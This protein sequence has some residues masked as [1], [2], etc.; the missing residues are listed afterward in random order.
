MSFT[1]SPKSMRGIA[2]CALVAGI[3]ATPW[4]IAH[5]AIVSS[6]INVTADN[7]VVTLSLSGTYE[8]GLFD[9]GGSEIVAFHGGSAHIL[10]VNAD[11][12]AVQVLDG[13]D[14][15]DPA[16]L[17][18]V[19]VAGTVDSLGD[20]IPVGAVA[21]S[22][23]VRPDGLGVIAVESNVKTDNGWVVFFDASASS[24]QIL[25][26]VRVG[27]Q[28]DNVVISDDGEFAVTANEGEPNDDYTVDPQ[29]SISVIELPEL[30][31]APVQA[32]VTN[33][34]FGDYEAGGV[35]ELPAGVRIFAGIDG[36]INPVAEGLEPEYATIVGGT[37][38]VTIQE[39]NAMAVVDLASG[40][41]ADIYYLGERDYS[42]EGFG[43]DPSDRDSGS[44]GPAVNIRTVGG[45]YGLYQP[46]T[47][48]H[49]STGGNDY[50]VTANEG[51]VREWGSYV[52]S[53]R[54][55]TLTICAD[56]PLF[57]MNDNATGSMIGRLNVSKE[58]GYDAGNACYDNLF[59]F[60]SR[61]FSI[62]DTDGNL[63]FDSGDTIEQ[64][65]AQHVP[66]YFNSTHDAVNLEGRS[67]DKGPEPEVVTVGTFAGRSY[68]F[69]G[70]ERIGGVMVFD[71][72]DPTAAVFQQYINNRDFTVADPT[73]DAAALSASG[74]LGPEGFWL[75]PA[76]ESPSGEPLLVAGNEITGSTTVYTID[77]PE[78]AML[79]STGPTAVAPAAISAGLAL[80]LG[81]T[82]VIRRRQS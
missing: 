1:R 15:A 17:Y 43:L 20:T 76:S 7:A 48:A 77:A 4:G 25:G 11:A 34:G 50:L 14:P 56:S 78:E 69:V 9:V 75:V 45:L 33:A 65:I 70:L 68:A 42:A 35:R 32:A 28:P 46:D 54:A 6:P 62:W 10:M 30:V 53:A 24:S 47:I 71:I 26:A 38:Y 27:A 52:E 40:S 19:T 49:Y 23:S 79:A 66:E 16:Y 67:D 22:V 58:S 80:A 51:D 21:N 73:V 41:V 39:S 2:A 63:V 61:S 64:L 74:D 82:I 29:G 81:L 18:D 60:G 12:G 55:S 8:T 72:T 36:S 13:S 31:E 44:A 37:A 59:T 3:V 5:A 57:G